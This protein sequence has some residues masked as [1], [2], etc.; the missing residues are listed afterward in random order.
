MSPSELGTGPPVFVAL[1]TKVRILISAPFGKDAELLAGA[2]QAQGVSATAFANLENL[3][4]ALHDEIETLIIS[5]ESLAPQGVAHLFTYLTGQPPWSDLP[6]ILLTHSG[7][8]ASQASANLVQMFGEHGNISMLQRPIRIPTLISAVTTALRA[9]RRQ[10][11]VR[12]LLREHEQNTRALREAHDELERRVCERTKELS[13]ANS[14]LHYEVSERLNAENTLRQL[15]QRMFVLQDEER[16]RIARDLHDS[17]GQYLSA[18]A[19]NLSHFLSV[20][21][22]DAPRKDV[23]DQALELTKKCHQEV[24]TISYLLHPPVLDELGLPTALRWYIDGFSQR[25]GIQVSLEFSEDLP[26][27]GGGL[28]TT[29]FRIIQEG[30]TNIHRHSGSGTAHVK[31]ES[32]PG[33]IQVA[34][35][36]TG[37]GIP[38]Q[39]LRKIESGK[40]GVGLT[41]M[42]ERARQ[43][44]GSFRINSSK[45]GTSVEITFP[46]TR[47]AS[48]PAVPAN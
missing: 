24:R 3:A 15:S 18:V 20:L 27:I 9:R 26:R 5:E 10:Y 1:P 25:S 22:A 19:L 30:L 21:P 8:S 31:I 12:D 40:S 37:Q 11:E 34:I 33:K 44:G 46:I 14:A 45:S 6:L 2:L 39:V 13:E 36:D 47:D 48:S 42:R 17:I 32:L 43:Q 29:L 7:R 28:E 23:V 38:Q 35:R 4:D 16:R 41:G